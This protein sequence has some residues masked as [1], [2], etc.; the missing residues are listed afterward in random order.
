MKSSRSLS[1]FAGL[2]AV[3]LLG[4][5]PRVQAAEPPE[6][7][8]SATFRITGQELTGETTSVDGDGSVR[9]FVQTGFNGL[10][11]H[12]E[13]RDR[14]LAHVLVT[15]AITVNG[16]ELR[17]ATLTY[18]DFSRRGFTVTIDIDP[19]WFEFVNERDAT[20][21]ELGDDLVARIEAA[22]PRTYDP[23][24]KE[25]LAQRLAF[26]GAKIAEPTLRAGLTLVPPRR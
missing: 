17:S 20:A 6:P 26:L 7:G 22:A 13:D 19:C 2:I 9:T 15:M 25:W 4:S 8:R 23:C 14:V 3:G 10:L 1:L 12:L 11:E 24:V 5:A 18:T 16:D 21:A